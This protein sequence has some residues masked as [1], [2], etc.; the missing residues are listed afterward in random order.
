[1]QVSDILA[2]GSIGAA[3]RGG[4]ITDVAG[5]RVGHHTDARRPTGCTVVLTEAGATGG[6]DVRGASPGTRETDLLDP[7]NAVDRVHAVVLAGG[8]AF[9]LDAATGVVDW[10]AARGVGVAVGPARVPIVPA[11]ILFDLWLGDPT[12]RPDAAGGRAACEAASEQPPAE[13]SVG[14]GAGATVGK[15]WGIANAMKGGVG[16]ASLRIGTVT[17]GALIVVNAIGDVLDPGSGRPLA[18][19]R[20]ADGR[21]L[22]GTTARLLAGDLPPALVPGL[23]TTIGVVATDAALGKTDCRRLAQCAHDG[24]ARTIDPVHTRFDGDT[25]FALATGRVEA[26][27]HPVVL[28]A[29][30]AAVTAAAVLRAVLA[31][32]G[33]S[34]AGLPRIPSVAD[35]GGAP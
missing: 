23:A 10:L 3:L 34:A 5:I 14:A 30:A 21:T 15:L 29:A 31:A 24:L 25:I 1:M 12:I 22:P 17:V 13:G 35:L 4:A 26:P 9:G 18:G 32:R 2:G 28:G 19:A 11:A 7:V 33:L 6:V 8:S 20:G 27:V 16:T